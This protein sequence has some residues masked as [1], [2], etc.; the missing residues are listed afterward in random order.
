MADKVMSCTAVAR[1]RRP[2]DEVYYNPHNPYTWG[3]LGSLPR[4]DETEAA[5]HT[6]RRPAAEPATAASGCPFSG[7]CPYEMPVCAGE[8]PALEMVGPGHGVH[9]WVPVAKRETIRAGLPQF[10]HRAAS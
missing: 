2:R 1:S 8:F 7:R 5:S 6:D 10:V 3:L 9:C 4:L